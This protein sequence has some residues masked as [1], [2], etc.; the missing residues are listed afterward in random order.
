[1][2]SKTLDKFKTG[3]HGRPSDDISPYKKQ[4]DPTYTR[5]WAMHIYSAFAKGT[6]GIS[7][8]MMSRMDY[9]RSYAYGQQ[10][11]DVYKKYFAVDPQSPTSE[12]VST[13]VDANAEDRALKKARKHYMDV[14][15][16]TIFSPAPKY[17]NHIIGR[18]MKIN[19]TA[20]VDAIDPMSGREKEMKKWK[21]WARSKVK[22]SMDNINKIRGIEPQEEPE[23]LPK[24][25][26]ELHLFERM[27]RFKTMYEV[28][29]EKALSFTS[30]LSEQP[31][32]Q[33]RV[34]QDL[35]T[36]NI[37]A[38][39]TTADSYDG[40]VKYKYI[41][42]KDLII[43][44]SSKDGFDKSN[45]YGYLD[46]FRIADIRDKLP[47][48]EEEEL[49]SLARNYQGLYGNPDTVD[50]S[51]YEAEERWGYDAFNVPVLRF[52]FITTDRHYYSTRKGK[53]GED[54][55]FRAEGDEEG[56]PR[57]RN[58]KKRTTYPMYMKTIYGGSWIIDSE[59][60]FDYGRIENVPYDVSKKDVRLPINVIKLKGRSVVD[61]MIPMLDQIQM[62]YLKLQNNIAKAPP[63]GLKI[64]IG[65]TKR[66][67]MNGAEFGPMDLIKL[68]TQSGHMVYDSSMTEGQIVPQFGAQDPGKAIEQLTGGA[69]QA[70]NEAIQS[71]EMAFSAISELTGIDRASTS[72]KQA[73][74]TSA[75]ETKIAA[76]G[77]SDTLAPIANAWVQLVKRA[78]ECAALRIQSVCVGNPE[79]YSSVIG[80]ASVHAI[81]QAG[82]NPPVKYG[83]MISAKSAED[84]AARVMEAAR[85][86]LRA[87]TLSFAQFMFVEDIVDSGGGV[88][89]AQQYIAYQEQKTQEAQAENARAAQE[90]D[91]EKQI[92]T[93][94][95]KDKGEIQKAQIES[96]LKREEITHQADE[97]I[98]VA[99]AVPSKS[100]AI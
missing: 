13:A 90:A 20:G 97:D 29:M 31:E 5:Q 51:Y 96:Q 62:T 19:L 53:N 92:V 48:V 60:V 71:W 23:V 4:N 17:I 81:R 79:V 87:G 56:R 35:L 83:I 59:H 89:M 49:E 46:S 9:L 68:Y 50:K 58:D 70:I 66:I 94:E 91:T 82:S 14:D 65:K 7:Q 84:E 45:Y 12:S 2:D 85:E 64:D 67:T 55:T 52:A 6:T 88:N 37:G 15:F 36:A 61:A 54:I 32:I 24:S 40:F 78:A 3:S 76:A 16:N 42:P 100:E 57:I 28:G 11:P 77:T 95:A 26:E 10:N 43:E 74:R 44:Y 93:Q 22:D 99:S 18:M 39:E 27:G 33:K 25:L 80:S 8:R 38:F 75:A 30:Q 34:I 41:D 73:P 98:R 1:M 86:A 47:H 72:S 63:S 69:G 21:T